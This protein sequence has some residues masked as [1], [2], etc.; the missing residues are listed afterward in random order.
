MVQLIAF[1]SLSEAQKA[2]VIADFHSDTGEGRLL[3][4]SLRAFR[5]VL[6]TIPLWD[7]ETGEPSLDSFRDT[8]HKG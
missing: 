5:E 3:E 7:P 1:Q 4:S 8:S 6:A 2:S